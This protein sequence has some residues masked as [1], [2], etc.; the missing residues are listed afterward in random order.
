MLGPGRKKDRG[1]ICGPGNLRV[2]LQVESTP[3][4]NDHA[5]NHKTH[6]C[7]GHQKSIHFQN[8]HSIHVKKTP[9]KNLIL[10]PQPP[11]HSKC[12]SCEITHSVTGQTDPQTH[13]PH[14]QGRNLRC[15]RQSP[16]TPKSQ[17]HQRICAQGVKAIPYLEACITP[18]CDRH[19]P[20][21]TVAHTP[22]RRQT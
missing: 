19:P 18:K 12:A 4:A 7:R 1:R 10:H 22:K 13:A 5:K 21:N 3:C 17:H 11:A 9:M 14:K 2:K 15:D 6:E 8:G 20:P 16:Q